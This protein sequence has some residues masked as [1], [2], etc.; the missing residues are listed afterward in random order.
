MK[1]DEETG[2]PVRDTKTGL[3]VRAKFGEPGEMAGIINE[4]HTF[5]DFQG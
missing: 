3:V 1:I 4:R 2:E 5:N